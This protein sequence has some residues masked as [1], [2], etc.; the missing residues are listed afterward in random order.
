[1]K[2]LKEF[3]NKHGPK[4]DKLKEYKTEI[5]D[6]KSEGYTL[7]QISTYLMEYYRIQIS[8]SSLSRY[9]KKNEICI[10]E[11]N[12]IQDNKELK[13]DKKV[14][15]QEHKKETNQTLEKK[16]NAATAL[17]SFENLKQKNMDDIANEMTIKTKEDLIK[18]KNT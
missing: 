7:L 10:K 8:L 6:L 1:M 2:N 4:K 9:I 18:R 17:K 14:Q 15:I 11:F 12:Q 13:E 3:K 5:F 16:F